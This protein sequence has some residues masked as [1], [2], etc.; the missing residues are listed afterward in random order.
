MSNFKIL[1][2]KEIVIYENEYIV[3]IGNDLYAYDNVTFSH[4]LLKHNNK[5]KIT[6]NMYSYNMCFYVIDERGV[7]GGYEL[8]RHKN[9]F[10]TLKKYRK[11]KLNDLL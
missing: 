8:I 11:Q 4:A 5:Y 6:Q 2:K 7:E 10:I 9:E 3:W 1:P